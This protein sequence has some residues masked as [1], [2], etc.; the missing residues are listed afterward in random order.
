MGG[1]DQLLRASQVLVEECRDHFGDD[2]PDAI[3]RGT[4]D[5][6][7]Y[8][9]RVYDFLNRRNRAA[10][11]LSG[12]GI[13]SATFGLGL[14]Q[15]L[16]RQKRLTQ[17]D[18]L[19]TVSGGGYIGSW[20][21]AWIH[22]RG[23]NGERVGIRTVQDVLGRVCEGT[24]EP[25]ELRHLR[26]YSNFLTPKVGLLSTDTWT[27]I[28]VYLRNLL[29]HW[30]M[31]LPLFLLPMFPA[32][33]GWQL[34]QM[35]VS[36]HAPGWHLPAARSRCFGHRASSPTICRAPVP[37]PLIGLL[38]PKTEQDKIDAIQGRRQWQF[39]VFG[40]LPAMT[41]AAATQPGARLVL[42]TAGA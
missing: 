2:I 24:K 26:D 20:L 23:P 41:A 9:E 32:Y 30:L 8:M 22:R 5:T 18:Y 25:R 1:S 12:G 33:V 13:R 7:E 17:F 34:L 3:L 35:D 27:T 29:L 38:D 6:P 37:W 4:E 42:E 11:C 19:S 21:S 15:G 31:L 10:L 39:L 28:A 36:W 14:L 16:A 40:L